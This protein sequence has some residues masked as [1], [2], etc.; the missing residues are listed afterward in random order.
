MR[1]HP[2][3][4]PIPKEDSAAEVGMIFVPRPVFRAEPID[5]NQRELETAERSKKREHSGW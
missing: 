4:D 1:S 5:D 2:G 3:E